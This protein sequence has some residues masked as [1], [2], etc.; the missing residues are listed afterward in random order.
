MLQKLLTRFENQDIRNAMEKI[1]SQE[2]E[3]SI[4]LLRSRNGKPYGAAS[5]LEIMSGCLP[6]IIKTVK[7]V[8][9]PVVKLLNENA[10]T[11][12]DTP[13]GPFLLRTIDNLRI[14]LDLDAL[15]NTCLEILLQSG[16]D[17]KRSN[18][19]VL[20][21]SKPWPEDKRLQQLLTKSLQENLESCISGHSSDWTPIQA[22]V[23]NQK[24]PESVINDILLS[25]I[26]GLNT[27]GRVLTSLDGLTAVI[28]TNNSALL[29]QLSDENG[30][31]LL[32]TL[33][34][35]TQGNYTDEISDKAIGL[36]QLV[37]DV[38]S[39]SYS[40]YTTS[41]PLFKVVRQGI[42]DTTARSIS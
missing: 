5:A 1:I 38:L 34:C 25:L 11:Y 26:S 17:R 7:S 8:R 28:Q 20:L 15:Y 4:G 24:I 29:S 40:K 27:P 22:S 18:T 36:K 3:A 6:Q 21:L 16:D 42:L 13:S 23:R 35:L 10:P 2:A 41:H 12:M 32:T 33:F 30:V 19:L 39:K 14:A 37:E 31:T 9:D